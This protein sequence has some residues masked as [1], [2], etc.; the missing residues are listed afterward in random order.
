VHSPAFVTFRRFRQGLRRFEREIFCE[1]NSHSPKVCHP[2]RSASEVEGP[3]GTSS[4][5]WRGPSTSLRS[6]R[7]DNAPYTPRC[8]GVQMNLCICN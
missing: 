1:A 2:E 3:R 6:A 7:D 5:S 4:E 8:V